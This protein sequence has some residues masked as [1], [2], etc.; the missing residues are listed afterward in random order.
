[1]IIRE[2]DQIGACGCDGRVLKGA[3]MMKAGD[4]FLGGFGESWFL[5]LECAVHRGAMVGR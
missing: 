5:S 3:L 4:G 2:G 1:M